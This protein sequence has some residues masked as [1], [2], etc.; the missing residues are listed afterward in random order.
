MDYIYLFGDIDTQKSEEII[1]DIQE[2]V[3]A[4]ADRVTL[5]INSDGGD[6]YSG[7]AIADFIDEAPI[8]VY[9]HALGKCMSMAFVIFLKGEER[10]CGNHTTFMTH[11]TYLSN[12]DTLSGQK[13]YLEYLSFINAKCDKIITQ[14]T[15][16]TQ[17]DIDNWNNKGIDKY[18]TVD[19]ALKY[20]IIL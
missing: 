11:E 5:V 18:F 6:V 15:K 12:G 2:K 7:L 4:G 14:N 10:T 9:T 20:G 3:E 1:R 19:E 13:S 8:H 17:E 16:I